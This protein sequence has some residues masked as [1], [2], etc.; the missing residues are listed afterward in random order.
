MRSRK[1]IYRTPK[2]D[3]VYGSE[4][5]EKLINYVMKNGKKS[6]SRSIVY[7]ALEE[8]GK[9]VKKS[10][11]EA[12]EV[13]IENVKPKIEVRSRRVGGANLQVPTPVTQR[14][15]LSLA[16]RWIVNFARTN[17]VNTEYWY[18]LARELISAYNKEGASY[19]KKEEVHKM[20]EANKAFS[21]FALIEDKSLQ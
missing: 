16:M 15:Q 1:V 14:R 4:L 13:A 17:R 9:A 21:Q 19:K 6:L 3:H 11:L 2:K 5:V 20:A 8:L 10:P 7:K 18:S 12:L